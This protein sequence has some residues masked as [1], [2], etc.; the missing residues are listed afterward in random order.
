[1]I[2]PYSYKQPQA[3]NYYHLTNILRYLWDKFWERELEA[4]L[5]IKGNELMQIP[6]ERRIS[7]GDNEIELQKLKEYIEKIR[8]DIVYTLL[9]FEI[10][11]DDIKKLVGDFTNR[12][13]LIERNMRWHHGLKGRCGWERNFWGRW[14][15][16]HH[17]MR[18]RDPTVNTFLKDRL[19]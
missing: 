12:I 19:S 4:Q 10:E 11:R 5:E 2:S 17:L 13:Y 15:M 16:F 7:L 3:S 14:H 18:R 9:S 8:D 1:M 6:G